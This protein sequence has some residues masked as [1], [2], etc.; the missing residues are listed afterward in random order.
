MSCARAG[1]KGQRTR[2]RFVGMW[3]SGLQH[4]LRNCLLR[5]QSAP[6]P[7]PAPRHLTGPPPRPLTQTPVGLSQFSVKVC[8]PVSICCLTPLT[9]TT[10]LPQR[11]SALGVNLSLCPP[12]V[13]TPASLAGCGGLQRRSG[14]SSV[15]PLSPA[16]E[17]SPTAEPTLFTL[18]PL[19]GRTGPSLT[20]GHD[21][22][23]WVSS[24]GL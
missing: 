8:L 21:I 22:R 12:S 24:S 11:S 13:P 9:R 2:V 10:R 4:A 15:H 3:A 23:T 17:P 6:D 16:P 1:S 18:P 19:P 14:L 20:S 5:P 7:F